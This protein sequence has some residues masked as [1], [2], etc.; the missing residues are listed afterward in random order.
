MKERI[1]EFLH[2]LS[3]FDYIYFGSVFALFILLLLLTLLLRKKLTFA[4]II[5]LFAILELAFGLT[6]GFK[7]FHDYLYK[8]SI[9][10]TK[11]KRLTFVKAVVIE[12]NLTNESRFD[13]KECKIKAKILKDTHNKFKNIILTLKPI[14]TKTITIHNI[15]KGADTTFKFL[16]EPFTYKKDFRVSVSGRC[17]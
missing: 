12:G 11:A 6:F 17:K 8:N 1:L 13:F 7:L 3:K 2:T 16:V 15:P 5:L 9:T 10:I 4:L 14:K